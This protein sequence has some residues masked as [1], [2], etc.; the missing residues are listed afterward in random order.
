MCLPA[1][2]M[3]H[4]C[5]LFQTQPTPQKK[6]NRQNKTYKLKVVLK[7]ASKPIL[8]DDTHNKPKMSFFLSFQV[9]HTPQQ[10]QQS[11]VEDCHRLTEMFSLNF[12][13]RNIFVFC[14]QRDEV[15]P[16]PPHFIFIFSPEP[17]R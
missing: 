7:G 9:P 8:L 15:I 1:S 3:S 4:I 6:K 17:K 12:P 2:V 10:Q 5:H 11:N 14:G 13:F 16:P